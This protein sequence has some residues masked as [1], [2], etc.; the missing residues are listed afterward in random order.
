[1][2]I[3]RIIW[4]RI[5]PSNIHHHI[6]S[7]QEVDSCAVITD[8]QLQRLSPEELS[9][10]NRLL[11]IYLHELNSSEAFVFL[12]GIETKNI[13][14]LPIMPKQRIATHELSHAE[15]ITLKKIIHEG[16]DECNSAHRELANFIIDIVSFSAYKQRLIFVTQSP[17]SFSL[18][19]ING[20]I[21]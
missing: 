21:S 2:L 16:F 12:E 10:T 6:I 8:K 19:I 17:K 5:M 3:H 13:V 4:R 7:S 15:V 14:A 18:N 9:L 11:S 20:S 1:M